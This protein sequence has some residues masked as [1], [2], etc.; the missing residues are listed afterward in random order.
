MALTKSKA[1]QR[2]QFAYY[3]YVA[4]P[5]GDVFL[6][7]L[8]N[9]AHTTHKGKK[10]A[11]EAISAFWKPFSAQALLEISEQEA[12][13]IALRSIDELQ[14]Q[15]DLIK[16]AFGLQTYSRAVTRSEIEALIEARL[17]QQEQGRSP[18]LP[19]APVPDNYNAYR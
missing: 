16:A 10:M 8:R 4:G 13:V 1:T 2:I 9:K 3:A 12:R 5:M 14:N 19:P 7:L 15:I 18:A 6:Y 11:L 17:S